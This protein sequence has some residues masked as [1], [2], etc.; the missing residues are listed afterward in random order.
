MRM[1][2]KVLQ[3]HIEQGVPD[4]SAHCAI[5][6]ALREQL[7]ESDVYVRKDRVFIGN[8]T[9]WFTD[10]TPVEFIQCFDAGL[11][12]EPIEFE[13]EYREA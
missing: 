8:R 9:W 10:Y 7:P 13:L 5:A 6:L 2:V 4:R 1:K 11:R 3:H 12:V